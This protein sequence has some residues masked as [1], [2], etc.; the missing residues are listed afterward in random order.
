M[1]KPKIVISIVSLSLLFFWWYALEGGKE[2]LERIGRFRSCLS[3]AETSLRSGNLDEATDHW[4]KA[5]HINPQALGIYNRLGLVYM[6]K[7]ELTKAEEVF[8]KAI[9][10]KGDYPEAHFN[11]ALISMQRNLY[12]D[13]FEHLD[14]VLNANPIYPRAHYLKSRLYKTLGK[15]VEAK[16]ERIAEINVH[17]GSI[18]AWQELLNEN[19]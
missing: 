15:E 9:D 1:F 19:K 17:P 10:L 5:L 6:Y 11:L 13:T 14:M 12:S 2:K 4:R 18:E 8:K 3:S 16:R 7:G